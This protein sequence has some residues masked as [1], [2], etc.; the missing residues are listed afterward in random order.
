V[1]GC[2]G[3][4]RRVSMASKLMHDVSWKVCIRTWN[5]IHPYEFLDPPLLN[6]HLQIVNVEWTFPA[7]GP[8]KF[9]EVPGSEQII[10]ADIVLL[11]MGFLGPEATLAEALGEFDK[12]K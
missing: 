12:G 3:E 10:E 8:P 7:D 9:A 5:P 6:T 11:A 1:G 2:G 4:R